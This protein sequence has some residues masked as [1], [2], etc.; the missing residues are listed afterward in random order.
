[1]LAASFAMHK[2]KT[3]NKRFDSTFQADQGAY[4]N[5][6]EYG[7]CEVE[8]YRCFVAEPDTI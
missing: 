2:A 8:Q 3:A 6:E 7:Q 5:D 4:G 1:M